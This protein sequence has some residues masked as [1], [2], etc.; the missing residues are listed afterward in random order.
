MFSHFDVNRNFPIGLA[1]LA[2]VKQCL[3][4]IEGDMVPL[5]IHDTQFE[6]ANPTL[7]QAAGGQALYLAIDRPFGFVEGKARNRSQKTNDLRLLQRNSDRQG[8]WSA[9]VNTPDSLTEQDVYLIRFGI[10]QYVSFAGKKL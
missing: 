9:V 2:S 6:F 4:L 7:I 5:G 1:D 3:P 8:V 10:Q